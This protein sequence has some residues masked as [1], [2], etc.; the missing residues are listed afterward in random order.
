MPPIRRSRLDKEKECE[1]LR[2]HSVENLTPD[3]LSK[4]EKVRHKLESEIERLKKREPRE[5]EVRIRKQ[6]KLNEEIKKLA[7]QL[8]AAGVDIHLSEAQ[9]IERANIKKG[10]PILNVTT[11]IEPE[12]ARSIL[13]FFGSE[14][15]KRVLKKLKQLRISPKG[16]KADSP[17]EKTNQPFHG[18]AFVLT[19]TLVS[20]SRDE[21]AEEIRN[22]GGNVVSAVS[23]NTNFL[24]VGEK[25]GSTKTDEARALGVKE[26]TENQF[27][28]MLG[29]RAKP[30]GQQQQELFLK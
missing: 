27:L 1:A 12:V 25:A 6:E 24:V 23:K 30:S 14:P 28:E 2:K 22:R 16:G 13:D 4:I 9:K 11:E 21:A 7:A 3:E 20:M 19:G 8:R 17:S 26:L 29:L 5:R 18:K 10:P 15:G